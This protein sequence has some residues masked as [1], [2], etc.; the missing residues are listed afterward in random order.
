M[1]GG[2]QPRGVPAA[3]LLGSWPPRC[4]VGRTLVLGLRA[5]VV[6][7]SSQRAFGGWPLWRPQRGGGEGRADHVGARAQGPGPH[8]RP[9]SRT[10]PAPFRVPLRLSEGVGAGQGTP[11]LGAGHQVRPRRPAAPSPA[12]PPPG[13]QRT[14]SPGIATVRRLFTCRVLFRYFLTLPFVSKY[15]A[16]RLSS[17][18]FFLLTKMLN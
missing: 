16:R 14:P 10:S 6:R 7:A 4:C 17:S 2:P 3:A 5:V 8:A 12:P 13:L 18:Y 1:R 11:P 15:F 9:R